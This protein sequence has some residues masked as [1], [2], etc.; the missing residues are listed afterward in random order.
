VT[1]ADTEPVVAYIGIGSNLDNPVQQ[2]R[3]AIAALARISRTRLVRHSSLYRSAPMGPQD[4]PDY[5]NAVAELE[6][7]LE[8]RA[9][10]T[11]LH[12]IERQHG[13]MRGPQR[14]GPRILDLDILVYGTLRLSEPALTIPHAGIAERAFVLHPLHEIAPTIRI[15]GLADTQTL[16]AQCPLGGLE[17]LPA[18]AA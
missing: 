3:S 4:Q 5:I 7:T 17:R 8:P 13:R 14:W 18:T 1:P 2:V 15:P 11:A 16:L 10:L 9:L 12:A 6:T